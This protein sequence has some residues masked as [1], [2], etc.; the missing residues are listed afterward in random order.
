M[1]LFKRVFR[2]RGRPAASAAQADASEFSDSE[3]APG[4][5]S[6]RSVVRSR[7]ESIHVV[8]RETMRQHAIPTDWIESRLLAD[9]DDPR[10]GTFYILL[11][12]RDG[13]AS[14]QGY[15]PTFQASLAEALQ[16]LDPRC[17]EWLAT[18][19]WSFGDF[20]AR[21]D[22]AHGG[23]QAAAAVPAVAA[24]AAV[25]A[26]SEATQAAAVPQPS[27]APP[28]GQELEEDL[29]ALFAIRDAAMKTPPRAD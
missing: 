28:G 2:D 16:R 10:L 7:R 27:R 12:V 29:Q 19:C 24:V 23:A 3:I 25:A 17:K 13:H 26:L 5:P 15:A 9:T 6:W 14:L 18:I 1:G 22:S 21:G 11:L 4:A 20:P 8:L